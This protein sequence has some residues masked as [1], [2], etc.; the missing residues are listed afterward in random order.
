MPPVPAPDPVP[1]PA[2]DRRAAVPAPVDRLPEQ[3]FMGILA[4]AARARALPGPRLIDLGRGNPDLPP[5]P[6]AV[7]ALLAGCGDD[8]RPAA[9]TPQR[10]AREPVDARALTDGQ[11]AGQRLIASFRGTSTPP[12]ALVR[13]IRRGEVAGVILFSDNADTVSRARRLTR[14]LQRIPR[15]AAL[16]HPLLV[17]VDQEGGPVRRL[18]DAPPRRSAAD[19]ARAG[20]RAIRAGGRA[21]GRALRRAGVNVNLAPVADVPRAGSAMRRER[22]T[23][24]TSA[25]Q[26]GTYA[27]AFARGLRDARVHATVKHFPGFGAATVNTDDAP[28]DIGLPATTLRTLDAA[29]FRFATRPGAARLVMLANATYP[30]FD[31]AR[32]ATLSRAI[33]T[34]ELRGRLR[35]TGVSIT[36]D[37]QAAA[38][39]PFGHPGPIA[40]ASAAAGADLLI[41]GRSYAATEEAGAALVGALRAGRLPRDEAR[42]AA[43]RVLALRADV[44]RPP[45]D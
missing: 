22:R 45:Q 27:A 31:R 30:A 5:P 38:L 20:E 36:D 42:A 29:T 17:M 13:R 3:Y 8:A 11:L 41:H 7:A 12:P 39:A 44:P 43:A 18:R 2:P 26:V 21:S 28:A 4:A 32:P 40:V 35:F 24:G 14:R 25:P 23:Y 33:A 9:S 16:P 34:D 1:G 19:Q 37:L 10:L 6:H 15:P